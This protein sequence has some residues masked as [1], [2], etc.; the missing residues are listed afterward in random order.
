MVALGDLA[1]LGHRQAGKQDLSIPWLDG[2]EKGALALM[3]AAEPFT[4]NMVYPRLWVG[5]YPAEVEHEIHRRWDTIVLCA[6]GLQP[7]GHHFLGARVVRAPFHDNMR[8]LAPD[9]LEIAS[10]AARH[11]VMEHQAGYRVLIT[12]VMGQNRSALVAGIAL[13]YLGAGTG[14]QIVRVLQRRRPGSLFNDQFRRHLES[15]R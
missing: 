5:S 8:E 2:D 11:V 14:A 4:S 7:P 3:A 12:C 10:R 13:H 1:R 6:H 15:L 9:Q